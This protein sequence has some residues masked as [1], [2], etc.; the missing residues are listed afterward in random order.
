LGLRLTA[1]HLLSIEMPAGM[2]LIAGC[3]GAVVGVVRPGEEFD[4]LGDL[5]FGRPHRAV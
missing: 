4:G 5:L 3:G 1:N 2:L